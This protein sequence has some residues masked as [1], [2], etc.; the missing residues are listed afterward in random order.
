MPDTFLRIAERLGIPTA[1]L[2]AIVVVAIAFVRGPLTRFADLL[3]KPVARL[4]EVHIDF[5]SRASAVMGEVPGKIALEGATTR[6][7]V[8]D[9]ISSAV[10]A[11]RDRVSDAE[12]AVTATGQH[13]AQG[14]RATILPEEGL[15]EASP[16]ASSPAPAA[17]ALAHP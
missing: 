8:S 12:R 3:A 6:A 2:F 5:V 1:I 16:A 9:E 13:Q 4:V 17:G 7:H 14:A 11:L 15:P 10:A